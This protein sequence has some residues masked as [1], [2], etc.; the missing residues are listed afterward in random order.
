MGRY[1]DSDI[2]RRKLYDDKKS[3]KS[4]ETVLYSE[5]PK[6]DTDIYVIS[7]EGDRLDNL[8]SQFYGDASLWWYI[9][10]ANNLFTINLE[11]NTSL[12]IPGDTAY[13]TT[14]KR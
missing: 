6:R 9:A 3:I 5:I 7:Q 14:L 11:P 2:V 13:A 12:R 4:Y 10:Q 1:G 8:A